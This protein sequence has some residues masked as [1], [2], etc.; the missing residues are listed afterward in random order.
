MKAKFINEKFSE[1]SDPIADMG[2][3]GFNLA[4]IRSKL[5][6]DFRKNYIKE[7]ENLLLNQTIKGYFNNTLTINEENNDLISGDGW[8]TYTIHIDEIFSKGFTEEDTSLSV[9]DKQQEKSFII[10]FDD[11]KIFYIK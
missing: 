5:R 6:S 4:R 7:I 11:K 10:P 1:K 3:G 2:I 9:Y 8:G